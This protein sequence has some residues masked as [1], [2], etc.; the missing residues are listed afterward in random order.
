MIERV[1]Q[2]IPFELVFIDID[3]P[4]QEP[5][6]DRYDHHVPVIHINGHE[7]ARHRLDEPAFEA[8][9]KPPKY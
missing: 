9:L 2:R 4:A 3:E 1:R 8:A 6:L 7:F 5:W